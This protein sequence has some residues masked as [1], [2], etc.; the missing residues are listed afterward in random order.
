MLSVITCHLYLIYQHLISGI[1]NSKQ[2]L[3]VTKSWNVCL[4]I[5]SIKG[6]EFD[7]IKK[8]MGGGEV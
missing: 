7:K 5:G 6:D 3:Q 1:N 2:T 8:R 4:E